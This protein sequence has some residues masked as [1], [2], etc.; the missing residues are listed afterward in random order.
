MPTPPTMRAGTQRNDLPLPR[1]AMLGGS[2]RRSPG[3][4]PGRGLNGS[5][6]DMGCLLFPPPAAGLGCSPLSGRT[7][8]RAVYSGHADPPCSAA[9]LPEN[10]NE[11][12]DRA[13]DTEQ[14]E[15]DSAAHGQLL[16]HEETAGGG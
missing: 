4:G 2:S 16:E 9:Q 11:D 3:M 6:I 8:R 14:P 5:S 7:A 12:D 13:G 15:Q 10:Q 1:G